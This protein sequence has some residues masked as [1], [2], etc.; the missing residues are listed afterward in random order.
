MVKDGVLIRKTRIPTYKTRF[1]VVVSNS[2]NR[3][4]DAVED[5]I[6]HKIM[7]DADRRSAVAYMYAF[8]DPQGRYHII[9]FLKHS[10]TPGEIA[11]EAKHAI[12]IAFKWHG[13]G[14]S[15]S[16]DENECYYLE[17][18]VNRVHSAVRE[19]KKKFLKKVL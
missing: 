2:I 19:Y 13:V 3:S 9:V 17:W 16:N 11:H 1:W 14:L 7:D 10:C 18:A 12:N 4:V 8:E 15:I 6:D 5:L